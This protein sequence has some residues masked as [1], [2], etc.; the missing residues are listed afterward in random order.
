MFSKVARMVMQAARQGGGKPEDNPKL[1]LAIEKAKQINMPKDNIERAIKKGTG[2]LEGVRFEELIYEAYGPGGVAFLVEVLTDNRNRT[3]PE[4][5]K[6]FETRGGSLAGTNAVAYLFKKKGLFSVPA[7]GVSEDDL[8]EATLEAGVESIE[9]VNGDYE[10]ICEPGDFEAV[11]E[12]LETRKFEISVAEIT[13]VA[14]SQVDIDNEAG[15]KI[16]ALMEALEDHDDVQNISTNVNFSE[17]MISQ[18]N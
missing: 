8:L 4:L 11:K 2:E 17:E 10:I 5:R 9:R 7:E 12:A 18:E 13:D 16:V 15:K 3:T 1:R 14:I 6:I